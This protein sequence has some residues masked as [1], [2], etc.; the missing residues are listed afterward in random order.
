MFKDSIYLCTMI[1]AIANP[2]K[3]IPFDTDI[4]GIEQ[5][6]QFNFPLYYSPSELARIACKELQ[7]YLETQ[8]DFEHNFGLIAEQ[9]GLVIGKMFGVLVVENHNKELGYLCA[10]SGKIAEKNLHVHFV[11]PVYDILKEGS[12]YKADEVFINE[13][14]EE[15]FQI[16]NSGELERLKECFENVKIEKEQT[17]TGFKAEIKANKKRR[18][19]IRQQG[20]ELSEEEKENLRRESV[21]E[22]L[23]LK[24][25]TKELK[26]KIAQ[27]EEDFTTF[28]NE[29]LRLKKHRKFLS[30]QLQRKIFDHYFFLNANKEE[31]SL[32]K[33]FEP[34]AALPPAGAGE[35]CAPKLM[36]Y[37]YIHDL[38]PVA[39]A[40]FWWGASPAS[41]VRQHKNFYP[42]CKSKCEPIL[43]FMLEGLD[44]EEN[45]LLKTPSLDKELPILFEDDTLL[46]VNKPAEMLSV[47][48]KNIDDSVQT[49]MRAYLPE[50]T[51]PLTVH[52]LDMSTSGI[53]LIA[54][55]LEAYHYLQDQFTRRKVD[56]TYYALLDGIPK[57]RE[58]KIELPLRVDLEDR[59]RQMVCYEHGKN[60]VTLYKILKIKDQ[61]TLIEF[62]PLTGRTH[63]LRVHA[64]HH[65]GLNTPIV[66]D[67]L[68]GQPA[69]RLHLHAGKISF[70]HPRTRELFTIEAP[71]PF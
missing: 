68:Y 67:D 4:K 37:A 17:I 1:N 66:G 69:N 61:K 63:Q 28:E 40:E 18:E 44:V 5:P 34:Y 45:P 26:D 25:I 36:H 33:I 22:Q 65:S 14:N 10:F 2:N 55:S 15:V 21:G 24:R 49:R 16:N 7:H 41:E 6:E 30:G 43:K 71:L 54:K 39:M 38:K 64:A 32:L 8:N 57:Q 35:C 59:P 62:K 27:A 47:P 12:F 9:K 20:I 29:L 48:G 46:I 42:A 23:T 58:G 52:R 19:S 51:G 53:L 60:G 31:K 13:V 11:P 3:W 56:K 50:A 70:I